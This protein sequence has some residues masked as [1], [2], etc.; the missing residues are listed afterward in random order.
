[1]LQKK[2]Q[3]K[4]SET[5]AIGLTV[6]LVLSCLVLSGLVL[7]H[8]NTSKPEKIQFAL[9]SR[10]PPLQKFQTGSRVHPSSCSMSI[11]GYSLDQ[12]IKRPGFEATR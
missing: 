4:H 6:S 7:M 5:F 10:V 1:M 9:R 12:R 3:H 11:V 2:K 8:S